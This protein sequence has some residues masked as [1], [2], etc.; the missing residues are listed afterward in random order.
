MG[1]AETMKDATTDP[2]ASIRGKLGSIKWKPD[3][4]ISS[5]HGIPKSYFDRKMVSPYLS[6][7]FN[8]T[9]EERT[10][11]MNTIDNYISK[12]S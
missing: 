3:L 1:L 10:E 2:Y 5:Y 9:I 7:K 11:L 6:K 8:P 4:I 12:I